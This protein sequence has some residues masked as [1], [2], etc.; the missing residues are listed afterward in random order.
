[1]DDVEKI[2]RKCG[3]CRATGH[4]HKNSPNIARQ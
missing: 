4:Y 3:V 1:M 2:P